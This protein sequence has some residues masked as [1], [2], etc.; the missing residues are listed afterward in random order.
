MCNVTVLDYIATNSFLNTWNFK[1]DFHFNHEVSLLVLEE[2]KW[3][4]KQKS[5]IHIKFNQC[6]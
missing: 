5:I 2:N 6:K 1:K 3:Y 4:I